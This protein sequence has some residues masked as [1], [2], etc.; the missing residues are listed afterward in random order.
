MLIVCKTCASSYHIPQEILGEN[1]CRLRCVGC[2]EISAVSPEAMA[3]SGA[4]IV[5]GQR[6]GFSALEAPRLG[7]SGLPAFPD[8]D[9]GVWRQGA[10]SK[11]GALSAFRREGARSPGSRWSLAAIAIIACAMAVV[12]A[13]KPIVK[14]VPGAA[15][16]FAAVGLPVNLSGLALDNVHT[17]IFDLGDRK[18]L[19]VEGAVVNL[20]DSP[21]ETPNMRIALRGADKRELYVWTAPA[22]KT[23]LGPNEQVAFR[24][25][26]AAPPDG[27]NDVLVK[28]ASVGDKLSP[29]KDGL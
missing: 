9:D 28:F 8:G 11:P 2:G 19:V 10:A 6:L 23:R 25:R 12:A 5:E 13:R 17:N 24:T 22:P 7:A 14:A 27:V 16:L 29:V 15:R 20:R 4:P 1:G 3:T 26:L 21:T 18:M